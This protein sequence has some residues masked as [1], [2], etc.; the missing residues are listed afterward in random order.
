MKDISLFKNFT[1]VVG[2]RTLAEIVNGIQGDDYKKTVLEIQKL[3]NNGNQEK[4]NQL[5]KRLVAFTV[6]GLFEGGRKMSF[7]KSYNPF[8]ILDIDKLDLE[9]LPDLVLKIKNIEF[10]RVVFISPSGRGLKIIVEVDS[11]VKMHGLAYR[12]VCNYY[13]KELAVEIDKSGKDITRLCFMSYDPEAYFNEDSTVFNIKK[14]NTD[15]GQESIQ[16]KDLLPKRAPD[17]SEEEAN[18]TVDYEKAFAICVTQ[19]DAK[20]VYKKGNRN[21]Y[22]YQ[23]GV[24]CNRAGIPAEVAIVESNRTFDL[25]KNELER[26]IKSAYTWKPYEPPKTS[27]ELPTEAPPAIPSKVFDKLP[28]IL[29]E[30]CLV[31]KDHRERDV[32][33]TGALGVLSGCLPGVSGIYDGHICYPNLFVF[34]IAPAASG[35]GALKFA[36]CLGLAYHNEL[37]EVSK[38][39][40][41]DYKN[42]LMRFEIESTKYK[43]GKLDSQ[44]EEPEERGFKTLFIPANSSS[45]MLIRHLNQNEDSGILF[46]SEADTLGNV[47][48]QDWGGYSDLMRKAYHHEAISYSRKS[49]SD[50]I[51][52]AHPKLSVA[53]SGTPGQVTSLIPSAEDGLFS[54]FVFYAFEVEAIWRDVSP[55]GRSQNFQEFYQGLSREILE[56]VHFLKLYP[57]EFDL[58][59]E[60]WKT[61]N[62]TF[63]KLM[64]ET[65]LMF[66][67]EALSIVKRMGLIC[68]RIAMILSAVR[69]FE[70]K[71]LGSKLICR[72][73]DF[74][75]AIWLA[76]TY[77]EHGVFVYDRLPRY[78][79]NKFQFKNV[80][81]QLFFDALPERFMRKEALELC[82]NFNISK[83]SGIRY[84]RELTTSGFLVQPPLG[85]FGEYCKHTDGTVA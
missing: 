74:Q 51:E 84:L 50:F 30:G 65:N 13:E 57:T 14:S 63:K 40:K 22:I 19:T 82:S 1:T 31:L 35:K 23:L 5:K 41:Q 77:F 49:N 25:T 68:F 62:E 55:E 83:R 76:Q 6:S 80:K 36:K 78:Q 38:K 44:P 27:L 12:Q 2:N 79:A 67:K 26:T 46:E 18:L 60:H 24:I 37:L 32:F 81:K 11:G 4:A 17:I 34:V 69:R 75:V 59:K 71:N 28:A 54:R 52:I 85:K 39:E 16:K 21:N 29:K 8:V 70:E 48:K 45:A 66:G 20:L 7:L 56:M 9:V 72:E 53:L 61:L 3:I 64:E 15:N 47:L 58:S 43:K 10:T 73:D 33:L 42:A